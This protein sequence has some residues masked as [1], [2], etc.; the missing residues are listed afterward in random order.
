MKINQP[1]VAG[2]LESGD[3]MIRIAPLDT[4][5]IDLQINS[6]VE[7][8]FG[9]AIRTTILDVLA[10]YNVQLNVD[11]KGALDCILRARLEALLARASGIPALPW[12]DCQ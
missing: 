11:D 4:Q 9:D 12:E 5:D 6:S 7:K 3:V 10:R 1:A 8:Q 2:T